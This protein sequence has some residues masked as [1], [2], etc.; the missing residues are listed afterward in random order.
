MNGRSVSIRAVLDNRDWLY[1]EF[2]RAGY[3]PVAGV[4]PNTAVCWPVTG[5]RT[6]PEYLFVSPDLP[7]ARPA[8]PDSGGR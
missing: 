5:M 4:F 2:V 8:A 1:E 6:R 3:R 7:A